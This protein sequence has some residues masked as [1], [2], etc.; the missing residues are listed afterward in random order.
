MDSLNVT[1]DAIGVTPAFAGLTIIALITNLSEIV[2]AI[3]FS[4]QND[5][6]L[7]LEIGTGCSIQIFLLQMPLL[8]LFSALYNH[9][10]AVDSFTLIFPWLDV[11][12]V[13]LA[14]L[15]VNYISIDGKANYFIG[16]ALFITYL[17]LVLAF[18]YAPPSSA[19]VV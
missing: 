3:R 1:L 2:N 6:A 18:W 17:I 12:A 10:A 14:L 8:V 9:G 16:S 11:I 13:T 4:L 5:F 19:T 7:A 15:V